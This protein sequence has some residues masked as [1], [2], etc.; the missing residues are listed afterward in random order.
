MGEVKDW[1]LSY[2]VSDRSRGWLGPYMLQLRRR[3]RYQ[4]NLHVDHEEG[5]PMCP[6]EHFK[7]YVKVG[8]GK[9]LNI[10]R[11]VTTR[12]EWGSL[13]WWRFPQVHNRLGDESS[14][15][16]G[17]NGTLAVT[18]GSGLSSHWEHPPWISNLLEFPSDSLSFFPNSTEYKSHQPRLSV[19]PARDSV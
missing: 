9:G 19:L 14:P 15:G 2:W 4:A 10:G 17:S 7:E 11:R 8:R 12:E 3:R 6:G 5:R 13:A 1:P 16:L 18:L